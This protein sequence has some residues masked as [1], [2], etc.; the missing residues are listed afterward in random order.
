MSMHRCSV[1]RLMDSLV[2]AV[3]RGVAEVVVSREE[4]L[5]W[6]WR[7]QASIYVGCAAA[8][9]VN[10]GILAVYSHFGR[11][12]L[13]YTTVINRMF[14]LCSSSR[15]HSCL[16]VVAVLAFLVRQWIS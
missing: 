3:L 14:L 15:S 10:Q 4:G 13:A 6:F 9:L 2:H 5:N 12:R 1:Q 11:R 8:F 16:Y 7:F